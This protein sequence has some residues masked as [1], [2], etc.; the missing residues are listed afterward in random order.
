MGTD[1]DVAVIGA[2]LAGLAAAR[3]L[4]AAGREP[5]VFEATDR[6]GG[7]QRTSELGGTVFEQGAVFFGDNYPNLRSLV[8]SGGLEHD[9]KPYDVVRMRST[10]GTRSAPSG[11]MPLL[12][13][14][15]LPWKEKGALLALG[16]RLTPHLRQIRNMLGHPVTAGWLLKLD[17]TDA[18]SWFGSRVGDRFTDSI[19]SP[20][21]ESLS[22]AAAPE[23]SALGALMLMAFSA[24]RHLYGLRNGLD[25]IAR[26]MAAE[27]TVKTGSPVTSLG[28][29]CRGVNVEISNGA[30][31]GG[32][33]GRA[34]QTGDGV[35]VEISNGAAAGRLRFR[36]VVVALPGPHAASL[37]E[38]PLAEAIGA[39]RYSSSVVPAITVDA[40]PTEVPA[41]S[42]YE[43]TGDNPISGLAIERPRPDGP[44]ICFA[45]IRPPWKQ[46]LLEAGDDEAVGLLIDVLEKDLGSRPEPTASAVARWRYAVPVGEPGLLGRQRQVLRLASEVPHLSLAGDW[47]VSPSQEGAIVSGQRAARAL[48]P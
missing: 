39:I 44:I 21:L 20:V 16:V 12:R 26:S 36:D 45:A 17:R 29:D 10:T 23:W 6:V 27:L 28:F 40:L 3:R 32:T 38:G 11:L 48:V 33:A 34:P 19:V 46:D 14:P 18:Q 8:S 5:I 24:S 30:A 31:A 42:F 2:G 35:N 47:L 7:R 37:L 1:G 22:F 25:Q 9:M 15:A 13:T 41:T 4:A 43:D